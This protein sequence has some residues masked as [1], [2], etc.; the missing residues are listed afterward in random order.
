MAAKTLFPADSPVA[1]RQPKTDR[2]ILERLVKWQAKDQ[3]LD[4]VTLRAAHAILVKWAALGSS[5]RLA[6]L[7]ETQLQGDFLAQV[8]GEALG[9]PGPADGL[10]LWHRIQHH[11][12]ADEHPMR[13]WGIFVPTKPLGRSR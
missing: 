7:S 1:L 13:Y 4:E 6:K 5:G 11:V 8:W 9:Y 3:R 10:D 12:I 2:L